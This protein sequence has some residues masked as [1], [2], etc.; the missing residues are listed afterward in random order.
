LKIQVVT[1]DE[2]T[3]NAHYI[4]GDD[5]KDLALSRLTAK[6]IFRSSI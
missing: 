4:T 6:R 2:K 5:K 1:N 3:Y